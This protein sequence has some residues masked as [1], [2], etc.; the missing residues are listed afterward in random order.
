MAQ[1]VITPEMSGKIIDE[2]HFDFH[3]TCKAKV[4]NAVNKMKGGVDFLKTLSKLNLTPD[5][6]WTQNTC[7]DPSVTALL[8]IL[9]EY[10]RVEHRPTRAKVLIP[11]LEYA[12]G[13]YASDLFFKERGAW[14]IHKIIERQQ[15]FQICHIQPFADPNQWYPMTRNITV[16]E[17]G[18]PVQGAGIQGTEGYFYK[19][20]N[21]PD[22]PTIEDDYKAWYGIDLNGNTIEVPQEIRER[23]IKQNQEWI[24][25]TGEV[26]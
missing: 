2:S 21:S 24:K 8:E 19:V 11:L 1:L 14:F 22:C 5:K 23:I 25:A 6:R 3:V 10:K 13:L 15:D 26:K 20:E 12:I 16:D 18:V 7:K 17:N 4:I 9:E